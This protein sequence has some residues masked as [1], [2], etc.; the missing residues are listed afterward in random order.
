MYSFK[1]S[2]TNWT[3]CFKYRITMCYVSRLC[4]RL[5][6]LIFFAK[7]TFFCFHRHTLLH[8]FRFLDFLCGCSKTFEGLLGF[9]VLHHLHSFLSLTHL[10]NGDPLRDSK[11]MVVKFQDTNFNPWLTRIRFTRISLTRLFKRFLFLT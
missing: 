11:L 4:C 7:C 3:L 6:F 10:E 9:L 2:F 1:G 5:E 8:F